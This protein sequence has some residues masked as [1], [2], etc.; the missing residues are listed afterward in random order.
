[1]SWSGQTTIFMPFASVRSTMRSAPA[2]IGAGAAPTQVAARQT[3][4]AAIRD[5][6]NDAFIAESPGGGSSRLRGDPAVDLGLEH[7]ERQRAVR[8][9]GRVEFAHIEAIAERGL[10]PGPQLADLE[11]ADLVRERLPGNRD[12]T[13]PET[14]ASAAELASMC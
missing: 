8:E 7:V 6:R 12:G 3:S 11:L 1:M 2:E 9:H 5:A 10:R 14:H 13:G 4:S